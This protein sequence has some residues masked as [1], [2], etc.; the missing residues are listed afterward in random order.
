MGFVDFEPYVQLL[1]LLHVTGQR[2]WSPLAQLAFTIN[3]MTPADSHAC[4]MQFQTRMQ[5]DYKHV[6]T[7]SA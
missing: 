5:C 1:D 4:A 6:P 2:T 7:A 3:Y